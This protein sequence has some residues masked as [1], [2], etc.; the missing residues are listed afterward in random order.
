VG[1]RLVLDPLSTSF[2]VERRDGCLAERAAAKPLP[3]APERP[4]TA[5][6]RVLQVLGHTGDGD[7]SRA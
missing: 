7:N 4:G 1:Q 2:A 3:P 5:W 6:R